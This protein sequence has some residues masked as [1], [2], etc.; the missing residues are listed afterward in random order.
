MSV[1]ASIIIA[2]VSAAAGIG[3]A[4]VAGRA[5]LKSARVNSE[6]TKQIAASTVEADAFKR[7]R[8]HYDAL[9]QRLDTELQRLTQQLDNLRNQLTQEQNVSDSLREQVRKMTARIREM[10]DTITELRRKLLEI[11]VEQISAREQSEKDRKGSQ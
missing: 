9:I 5:S 7:A 1:D 4:F 6:T 8:E 11:D 2:G 10:E 3:S